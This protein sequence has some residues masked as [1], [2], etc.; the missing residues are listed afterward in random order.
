MRPG[1]ALSSTFIDSS[2][3]DEDGRSRRSWEAS[4]E[5]HVILPAVPSSGVRPT[6][7][8]HYIHWDKLRR[9]E[10]QAGRSERWGVVDRHPVGPIRMLP[11]TGSDP[12]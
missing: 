1:D 6:V 12:S 9:K 10:I 5:Q 11:A 2:E 4:D 8:G 3:I 7:D